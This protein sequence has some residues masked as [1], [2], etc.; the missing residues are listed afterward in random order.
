MTISGRV[1]IISR[2]WGKHVDI[3]KSYAEECEMSYN[4]KE[5]GNTRKVVGPGNSC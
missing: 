3:E 5:S 2:E 1:V 4:K